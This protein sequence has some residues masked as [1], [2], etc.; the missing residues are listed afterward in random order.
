MG[1][2]HIPLQ[3]Q[4]WGGLMTCCKA[5][6]VGNNSRR[7]P[8]QIVSRHSDLDVAQRI[9]VPRMPHHLHGLY[10]GFF[11]GKALQGAVRFFV[12]EFAFDQLGEL[13]FF[14]QRK[15]HFG[16]V[17]GADVVQARLF[18]LHIVLP[19]HVLEQGGGH[20]VF[21]A[22][23]V[24]AL[25]QTRVEKID[26]GGLQRGAGNVVVPGPHHKHDVERLQYV[27]VFF[28]RDG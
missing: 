19:L 18:A 7:Q 27:E 5:R 26:L 28:E 24:V 11:P 1:Q 25:H 9:A 16:T 6:A 20:Q 4:R 22:Q 8:V 3:A 10:R 15:V 21:K 23:A 2:K 14:A 12:G 13:V 17:L